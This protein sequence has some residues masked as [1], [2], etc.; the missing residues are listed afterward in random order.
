MGNKTVN[1]IALLLGCAAL[2]TPVQSAEPALALSWG[3]N[4]CAE[5]VQAPD[6]SPYVNYAVGYISG[7]N[8]FDK[9]AARMAGHGWDGDAVTVWLQNFC[10]QHPLVMFANAAM[11]LRVAYGGNR[12]PP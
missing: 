1:A 4:S 7:A 9:G 3:I 6:K 11:E 5:F 2:T 12:P 10:T 8:A